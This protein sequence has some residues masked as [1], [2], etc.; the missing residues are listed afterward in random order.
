MALCIVS[1]ALLEAS[2]I[3]PV[4]AYVG[5]DTKVS[6]Q[7]RELI[8][9]HWGLDKPAVE[10][11]LAWFSSICQGDWGTSMIYR[12]PVLEVIGDKFLSSIALMMTAWVLSGI[13]GFLLGVLSGIYEGSWL[14]KGIRIYCHLLIST[15]T[16][17][18]G[19]VIP[20]TFFLPKPEERARG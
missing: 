1:F 7:Q 3:D 11:F 14:D 13:F 17:W 4:T 8:A 18:M 20:I 19:I 9:E 15:P 6:A 12:R 10:R 5:A 2:P 16:F